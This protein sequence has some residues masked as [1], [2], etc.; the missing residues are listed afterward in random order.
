MNVSTVFRAVLLVMVM[1]VLGSIV[2]VAEAKKMPL[3]RGPSS[4]AEM[5]EL[6]A[7]VEA[8]LAAHPEGLVLDLKEA[9]P[10]IGFS[11]YPHFNEPAKFAADTPNGLLIY[12]DES[13]HRY[14]SL[15]FSEDISPKSDLKTLQSSL[16]YAALNQ[17]PMPGL[18]LPGWN[19]GPSTPISSFKEGVEI[20]GFDGARIQVKIKT[21][22]FAV[23]GLKAACEPLMMDAPTPE[24]C[25]FQVR[26]DFPLT[27]ALDVPVFTVAKN[28][29]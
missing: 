11:S 9:T 3:P 5:A 23:Y 24:G 29:M 25:Y 14:I 13:D 16:T 15:G 20:V 12:W 2:G 7:K 10:G 4:A 19:F 8:W 26:R 17:L 1:V 27:L 28:R 18:D 21:T 22:F 6:T